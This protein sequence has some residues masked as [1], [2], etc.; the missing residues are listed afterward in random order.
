[1]EQLPTPCPADRIP[2][3]TGLEAFEAAG[4]AAKEKRV[5][6][7]AVERQGPLW[8]VKADTL[9]APQHAID[10]TV[11][12]AVREAVIRLIHSREIRPDSCAGPVYFVLHHVGSEGRARELAA[13]LHAAL[14]GDLQPLARAVP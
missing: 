3:A 2:D 13:A 6:F 7:I 1:M 4:K 14:Y 5:V 10:T 8:A 9:S 11:Y 12:N